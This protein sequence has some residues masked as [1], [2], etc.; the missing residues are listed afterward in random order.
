MPEPDHPGRVDP[1]RAAPVAADR[2]A[3]AAGLVAA[4]PRRRPRAAPPGSGTRARSSRCSSTSRRPISSG[5]SGSASGASDA[6]V[7]GSGRSAARLRLVDE[8]AASL[9]PEPLDQGRRR[10][11]P[12]HRL[13]R[14]R[15]HRVDQRLA[16]DR[17]AALADPP[18]VEAELAV[19]ADQQREAEPAVGAPSPDRFELGRGVEPRLV[20]L[21]DPEQPVALEVAVGGEPVDLGADPRLRRRVADG[22]PPGPGQQRRL[23][24]LGLQ[25]AARGDVVEEQRESARPVGARR[26]CGR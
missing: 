11:G 17:A 7:T 22:D 19:A 5:R 10:R 6:Q 1:G 26:S 20:G 18:R 9:V 3:A 8:E 2:A 23:D 21:D 14:E 13:Q 12:A 16:E 25:R 4:A 15:P 24:R